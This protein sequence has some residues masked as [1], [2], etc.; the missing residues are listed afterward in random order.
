MSM[1]VIPMP[2]QELE[3]FR[4]QAARAGYDTVV[5]YQLNELTVINPVSHEVEVYKLRY[6]YASHYI[7]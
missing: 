1:S 6:A 7:L 5:D 2:N 3:Q 4:A